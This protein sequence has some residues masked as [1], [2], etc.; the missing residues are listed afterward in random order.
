MQFRDRIFSWDKFCLFDV[1]ALAMVAMMASWIFGC[2]AG[3]YDKALNTSS[4]ALQVSWTSFERWDEYH[5][6]KIIDG[7]TPELGDEEYRRCADTLGAYYMKRA[8][9]LEAYASAWNFLAIAA[10][11]PRGE[12]LFEAARR[13]KILYETIDELKKTVNYKEKQP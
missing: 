7:C 5:Q 6:N 2:G 12:N 11:E 10:L 13:I 1:V 3:Q 8:V 4:K 9:V